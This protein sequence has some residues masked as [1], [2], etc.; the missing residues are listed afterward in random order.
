MIE[1]IKKNWKNILL[2]LVV[3]FSMNKCTQSCS[4]QGEIDKQ[5][6]EIVSKDSINRVQK[7]TIDSMKIEISGLNARLGDRKEADATYAH[8]SKE[9]LDNKDT[10]IKQLSVKLQKALIENN[11]LKKQ[12]K[13][14]KK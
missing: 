2:V 11:E 13:E 7:S 1:K 4:R 6:I 3:L 10:Q 9:Q 12:I 5:K 14:L 8:L